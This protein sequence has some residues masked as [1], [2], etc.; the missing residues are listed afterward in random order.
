M[1]VQPIIHGGRWI[2]FTWVIAL[3]AMAAFQSDFPMGIH[4]GIT[5]ITVT[6]PLGTTRTITT[7]IVATGGGMGIIVNPTMPVGEATTVIAGVEVMTAMQ[8]M[9]M[10]TPLIAETVEARMKMATKIPAIVAIEI[11]RVAMA[12]HR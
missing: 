10:E 7:P 9:A 1:Q 2:I 3:M 6:F 12:H 4:P 8:T 5:L 11:V